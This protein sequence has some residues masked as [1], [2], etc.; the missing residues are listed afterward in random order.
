M[1]I[2]AHEGFH[3]VEIFFCSIHSLSWPLKAF[4]F[5]SPVL[6]LRSDIGG[7]GRNPLLGPQASDPP[8][9]GCAT[10]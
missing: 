6:I 7:G 3:V 9:P 8:Y 5:E 1:G 10:L 2:L 4:L